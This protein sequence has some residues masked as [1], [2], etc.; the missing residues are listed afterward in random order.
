MN[1]KIPNS[2]MFKG[3]TSKIFLT[4]S[5]LLLNLFIRKKLFNDIN[6]KKY[7]GI[8][9]V[10][11]NKLV[12]R[13]NNLKEVKDHAF[14]SYRIVSLVYRFKRLKIN[15]LF[16]KYYTLP[17]S[18]NIDLSLRYIIS[19]I[20]LIVRKYNIKQ[21]NIE[22]YLNRFDDK[23]INLFL[24]RYYMKKYKIKLKFVFMG[25]IIIPSNELH[26]SYKSN[27]FISLFSIFKLIPFRNQKI[28]DQFKETKILEVGSFDKVKK[29][30]LINKKELLLQ[31]KICSLDFNDLFKYGL[32]KYKSILYILNKFIINIQKFNFND[33]YKIAKYNLIKD[34]IQININR[35]YMYNISIFLNKINIKYLLCSHRSFTY[36]S[37]IYKTC[38]LSKVKSI[39]CDFSLGYPLKNIYKKEI[40]LT[41]KPDILMVNCLFR[42][43]QYLIAN[44]GYINSGNKL[45]IIN[46]NC[47]QVEY[48]RT[49]SINLDN[50]KFPNNKTTISIFDNNYG[51]NLAIRSQYTKDLAESLYIFHENIQCIVHAKAKY[52]NLENELAKNKIKFCKAIKGDFS[53]DVNSDLIISI[54]F[55]GSAIKAAFAFNKPI[56]FF[57]SDKNYFDNI[58]FFNDQILNQ[59][60]LNTFEELIFKN[61]TIEQLL[62]QKSNRELNLKK[63]LYTTKNFL[64]LIG[65]TDKT[66]NIS[67][68]LKSIG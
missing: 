33:F 25:K 58:T 49:N 38:K 45:D 68:F 18:E 23:Y 27:N 24:K 9:L 6:L 13:G 12:T 60:L 46:C 32:N 11:D 53:L 51:E 7:N 62:S 50:K 17:F 21:N 48:A 37:L 40:S 22:I 19:I 41:T 29:P 67:S 2:K 10:V 36:E 66:I 47:T 5:P 20:E 4:I 31:N 26:Y 59:E 3:K 39:V 28:S 57:T 16:A 15:R 55:Q 14:I 65:I 54:G 64:R 30:Y 63:L 42:K 35:L 8:Y 56:I 1:K 52:F 61:I 34:Y 44:K 43:E